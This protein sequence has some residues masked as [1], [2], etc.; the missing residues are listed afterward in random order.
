MFRSIRWRIATAFIVLIIVC[1]GGL[2]AY[3][4]HFVRGN[5]LNNLELQLTNQAQLIGDVSEPYF[6]G[7]WTEDVDALAKK[8]GEQID[9]RITIIDKGGVVLGDSDKKPVVMENH[10]NRPEVTQA[11]FSG[12][13]TSIRYSTTLGCDM[14]YVAIPVTVD[15]EVVGISRV[16][17]PLTEIN[18]SLGHISRIIIGGAVIATII[19]ILLAIQISRT[20]TEP[21]KKLTQISKRM[22]EGEFDLKI[23]VTSRDEVGDLAGAF[24]KMMVRLKEMIG[25]LTTERD[26]M[27]AILSNMADG[28]LV[29]DGESKVIMIN[30]AG[31]K[32]FQLS[33]DKALGHTFIEV[34][35]DHEIDDILQR[36]L[37]TREQQTGLVEVEPGKQ[38]L[39]VIATPLSGQSGSV[40]LLQDLTEIRRLEAVRRDFISNISHELRT[41]VASLKVLAETLQGGVV[42]DPVVTKDFLNRINTETD[43]LAQMVNELG[44]LYR[45]ESGEVSLEMASIDVGEV[46]AQTV[47]RLKAQADRA[48]LSL[49]VD[50]P[51]GLPEAQADKERVEQVLVNLLHNAIKFTPSGG[52]VNISAKAEGNSVQVSVA[53]TGVGIPADDLPHIFERFYKADKARAGGGTGLGLAIVKHVVEA[54][55]SKVWA[56]SIEGKGATF[57]FTLPAALKP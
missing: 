46:V 15:D 23:R 22:A 31:E 57:T 54:H 42:D 33:P 9:S 45:I 43:R 48:G 1:I 11:L 44:E 12:L 24:N 35:H 2:S 53:D 47:G 7:G 28:I 38:F 51:S 25:L 6:A 49:V 52:R 27:S 40:V 41:P 34:V 3:L 39:G 4:M 29:I 8:L 10:S 20:T 56:K 13:G 50:I 37:N 16:S 21:V 26:R 36:C 5:Y 17:L 18:K 55:G 30:Q 32:I 19:A 14:M